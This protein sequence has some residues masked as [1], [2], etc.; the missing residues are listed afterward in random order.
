MS[1]ATE[2]CSTFAVQQSSTPNGSVARALADLRLAS[3][4]PAATGATISEVEVL[5]RRLVRL[6]FDVHDGPMQHLT[7]V[8]YSIH[9]LQRRL[10]SAQA[11][12]VESVSFDLDQIL[13]A[14]GGA[15]RGLRTLISHL[16]CANP[17]IDSLDQILDDEIDA[18]NRRCRAHVDLEA[19]SNLPLDSHSQAV[20]IRS[21]LREALT[22]IAK[23]AGAERVWIRIEAGPAGI[24]LEIEDDGRGF[25]PDSIH[26][27]ALGLAGMNQRV[28]LLGGDFD[29]L[30]RVGGPTVVTAR[31]RRWRAA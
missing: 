22:N 16:E 24:L 27:D 19:P 20:A 28:D 8:G 30:S 10:H 14:L 25:D 23:H 17:E 29:V 6:A 4:E 1:P 2:G 15:E 26:T 31:F 9:E 13:A 12:D 7:A 3:T 5:R 18:F 11:L 21:I